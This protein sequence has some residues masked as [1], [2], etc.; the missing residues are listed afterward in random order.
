MM[1]TLY[2]HAKPQ[3]FVVGGY[4]SNGARGQSRL[5][6]V[7]RYLARQARAARNLGV[8]DLE[9]YYNVGYLALRVRRYVENGK[10]LSR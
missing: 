4:R 2:E 10:E 7:E 9:W 5:L 8:R 1:R 6:C 3:L